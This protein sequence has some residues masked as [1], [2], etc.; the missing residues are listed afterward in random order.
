M[1]LTAD[2]RA[3][4]TD[5]GLSRTF[6]EDERELKFLGT[7][8]YLDP[9][10]STTGHLNYESLSLSDTYAFGVLLLEL[11]TGQRASGMSGTG[12]H[13]VQR[14]RPYL[15]TEGQPRISNVIDPRLR[16]EYNQ[17]EARRIAIIA[18]LCVL[19][20]PELRPPMSSVAAYLNGHTAQV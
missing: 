2:M 13:I 6:G 19:E 16:G 15:V 20:D 10:F 5:Y 17:V 1:L 4:I 8:G 12:G 9:T 14:L 7:L 18:N 11:I 3:C